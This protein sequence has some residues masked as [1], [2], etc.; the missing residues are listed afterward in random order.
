MNRQEML[1][2]LVEAERERMRE[3]ER[4]IWQ[5][6]ETGFREWKTHATLK[7]AMEELGYTLREAGDIPGFRAELDTGRPGPTVALLAEMDS[8]IC[9]SHPEC[10]R[11]TGAVHACGHHAQSAALLGAAAA[12]R[13]PGALDGLCGRILFVEVPAEELLE[14]EYREEL[15]KKGVIRYFGGKLE[16]MR[17]GFFDDADLC[18]ML[19]TG[20]GTHAF[21]LNGGMNGCIVKQIAYRGRTAHAGGAPQQGINSLYA[22]SMGLQAVNA[23][24]ET[25]RDQD[26]VR[27]HPIMTG[28]VGTVNNIPDLTTLESYVRASNIKMLLENNRKVNRAFISGALALGAEVTILD[29]PGYAPVNNDENMYDLSRRV[30][31]S[32][33]GKENVRINPGFEGGST[34]M[35]DISCVFPAIHPNGS[36]AV[37]KGHG[38]DYRIADFDSAVVLAAQYLCNMAGTLL[39]DGAKEAEYILANRH[40]LYQSIPEYLASIDRIAADINGVTYTEQGAQIRY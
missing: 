8:V 14:L 16:F 24:R 6:P 21:S 20:G 35:G 29:R 28:R 13:Q 18:L 3:A 2:R 4:T 38:D 33:V 12:L 36:G 5:H 11:E 1:N 19:H 30:M 40:T 23:I 32:L 26:H 34:D 39:A 15:R 17:R 22:A 27:V 9:A 25:F 10:D 7:Q 31:E 37:G